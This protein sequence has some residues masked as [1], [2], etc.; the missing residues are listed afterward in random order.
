M[1]SFL[2]AIV[3]FCLCL[4]SANANS[5]FT[6][7]MQDGG[8]VL[9]AVTGDNVRVRKAPS[10][11]KDDWIIMTTLPAETLLLAEQWPTKGW[12]NDHAW[13]RLVAVVQKPSGKVVPMNWAY[14]AANWHEISYVSGSFAKVTP[15][16]ESGLNKDDILAQLALTP[17]GQGYAAI[18]NSREGQKKLVESKAIARNMHPANSAEDALPM[19]TGPSKTSGQVETFRLISNS[20]YDASLRAVDIS[21]PGWIRVESE[22]GY[23]PSGWIQHEL[24]PGDDSEAKNAGRQFIFNIGAN[25]PD[26]IRRWGPLVAVNNGEGDHHGSTRMHFDGMTVTYKDNRNMNAVLDRKGA[27]IGGIFVNTEGYDKE[28]IKRIYG[29]ILEID[30]GSWGERWNV[31]GNWDGW[32]YSAA[33]EFNEKGLV[34]KINFTCE[35]VDLSH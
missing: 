31:R 22:N 1:K 4:G 25:V 21:V 6:A 34:S 9:L 24:I 7:P 23:A 28:Y 20:V 19:Y 13:Y 16:S 17:Y 18:D 29:D 15:W 27:G 11:A 35:D 2:L 3:V 26:I 33:L 12:D 30:S 10:V 8:I 5:V 32:W 14:P